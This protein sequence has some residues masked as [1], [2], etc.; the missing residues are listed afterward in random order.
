LLPAELGLPPIVA[1]LLLLSYVY[2]LIELC[3]SLS[4]SADDLVMAFTAPYSTQ[5]DKADSKPP[6]Q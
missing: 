4:F 2:T 3:L 1:L 5:T 6:C